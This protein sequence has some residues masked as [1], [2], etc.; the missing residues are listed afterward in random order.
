[1]I[2]HALKEQRIDTLALGGEKDEIV[3]RGQPY[4][5]IENQHLEIRGLKTHLKMAT[6]NLF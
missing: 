5:F 6:I 4:H 2:S 3:G 1:M